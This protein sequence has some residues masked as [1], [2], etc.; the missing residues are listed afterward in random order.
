ME[1]IN[2]IEAQCR[3]QI[4]HDPARPG[5][6]NGI[7]QMY[8]TIVGDRARAAQWARYYEEHR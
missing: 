1:A 8:N 6:A 3:R 7:A 4:E 5:C 2:S